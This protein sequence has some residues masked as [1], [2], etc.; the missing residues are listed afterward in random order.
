MVLVFKV[1]GIAFDGLGL[2]HLFAHTTKAVS[3]GQIVQVLGEEPNGVSLR[4][5]AWLCSAGTKP[6]KAVNYAEGVSVRKH[7]KEMH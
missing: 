6:C 7:V 3:R 2:F 4:E 5:R 1:Y